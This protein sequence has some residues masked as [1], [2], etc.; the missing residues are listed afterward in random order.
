MGWGEATDKKK[1]NLQRKEEKRSNQYKNKS[2]QMNATHSSECSLPLVLF[3]QCNMASLSFFCL[4]VPYCLC[5]CCAFPILTMNLQSPRDRVSVTNLMDSSC[6]TTLCSNSGWLAT[7]PE[8]CMLRY[9]YGDTPRKL[10]VNYTYG[11]T[12]QKLYADL[13][14]VKAAWHK[15]SMQIKEKE[16]HKPQIPDMLR[17]FTF[18]NFHRIVINGSCI[19]SQ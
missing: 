13:Y 6:F 11:N 10:Y 16:K 12:P 19:K 4:L 14:K 18:V 2:W 9:T 17:Y 1:K 8:S 7:H 5:C 3:V 15:S